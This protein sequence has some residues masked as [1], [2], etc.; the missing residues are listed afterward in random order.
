MIVK[1]VLSI[2]RPSQLVLVVP[3][4]SQTRV[5]QFVKSRIHIHIQF[6]VVIGPSCA[7]DERVPVVDRFRSE[8]ARTWWWWGEVAAFDRRKVAGTAG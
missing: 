2:R 6:I 7:R 3:I 8:A 1:M 4:S 5:V